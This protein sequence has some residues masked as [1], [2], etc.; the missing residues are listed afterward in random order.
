MALEQP[1]PNFIKLMKENLLY[2][3]L[4]FKISTDFLKCN[5][6]YQLQESEFCVKLRWILANDQLLHL[7]H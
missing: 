2:R 3:Y 1:F 6:C 7:N 4:L 5:F